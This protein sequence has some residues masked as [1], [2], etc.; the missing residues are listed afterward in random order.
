MEFNR[1]FRSLVWLLV[2]LA[3][4][5]K[6]VVPDFSKEVNEKITFLNALRT[7][8]G[9]QKLNEIK[10]FRNF[11]RVVYL[12]KIH[13][14]QAIPLD[15]IPTK[16]NYESSMMYY[17]FD[18]PNELGIGKVWISDRFL[19]NHFQT[20]YG[21]ERGFDYDSLKRDTIN[22]Y[23]KVYELDLNDN[24]IVIYTD[25]LLS[26]GYQYKPMG[27]LEKKYRYISARNYFLSELMYHTLSADKGTMVKKFTKYSYN[28]DFTPGLEFSLE[29]LDSARATSYVVDDFIVYETNPDYRLSDDV[30]NFDWGRIKDLDQVEV[31][32][33]RGR[34]YD[35]SFQRKRNYKE[36]LVADKKELTGWI[37]AGSSTNDKKVWINQRFLVDLEHLEKYYTNESNMPVNSD[38]AQYQFSLYNATFLRKTAPASNGDSLITKGTIV[39][40]LEPGTPFKIKEKKWIQ[41]LNTNRTIL[42]LKIEVPD[43]KLLKKPKL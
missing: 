4:A 7:K 41:G 43:E 15:P 37:Y 19:E 2:P 5:C 29:R 39:N 40:I 34:R 24:S 16:L 36:K 14:P 3:W 31:M 17:Y 1:N 26:E 13:D 8:E 21:K 38:T 35:S 6:S 10:P 33:L 27:K 18:K 32:K 9:K 12:R 23:C 20:Y 30:A 25:K 42:W 28:T 11:G 22:A